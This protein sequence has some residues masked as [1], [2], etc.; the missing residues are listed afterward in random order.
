[1]RVAGLA[2]V[3][4]LVFAV[5]VAAGARPFAWL[6]PAPA[7]RSW[8]HA[9]LPGNG[10]VM[11]YPPTLLRSKGDPGSATA[12]Q[13]GTN[14]M[15]IAYL[16]AVPKQGAETLGTWP[17]F[18]VEHLRDESASKVVVEAKGIALP[19]RS[20]IGSCVDDVYITRVKSHHYHEIA[21]FVQGRRSSSV[22]VAA[23]PVAAW[24]RWRAE[25][26]KA[27]AAYQAG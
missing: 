22:I 13:L 5:S 3:F 1:M 20:A 9:T 10:A 17:E 21:C 27:V 12:E 11:W 4:G 25:L 15:T 2:L 24:N 8:E 23:T 14:G 16:N 7:P 26:E 6:H 19:F 18:R